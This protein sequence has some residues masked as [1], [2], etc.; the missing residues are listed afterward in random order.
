MSALSNLSGHRFSAVLSRFNWFKSV[1]LKVMWFKISAWTSEALTKDQESQWDSSDTTVCNSI[2]LF[3]LFMKNRQN[4]KLSIKSTEKLVK[5]NMT[6]GDAQE[7]E[8]E[9]GALI[10]YGWGRGWK[11]ECKQIE[12]CKFPCTDFGEGRDQNYGVKAWRGGSKC[13]RGR[14]K[15]IHGR[16]RCRRNYPFCPARNIS[17]GITLLNLN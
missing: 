16:A 4:A 3:G 17:N 12:G 6:Q 1:C 10:I 11:V 9:V 14:Q 2:E 13:G 7:V 8:G 15:K 5:D